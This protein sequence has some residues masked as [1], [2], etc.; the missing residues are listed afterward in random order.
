M[1]QAG[2]STSSV[3]IIVALASIA[4]STPNPW[5]ASAIRAR[6]SMSSIPA[7]EIIRLMVQVIAKSFRPFLKI[8]D[9]RCQGKDDRARISRPNSQPKPIPVPISFQFIILLQVF[10]RRLRLLTGPRDTMGQDITGSVSGR[11]GA[12]SER[13]A[14]I[15]PT[16]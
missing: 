5:F 10:T 13:P 16:P 2:L 15:R 1:R 7:S 12:G 11:R 3:F 14:R 8:C 6:V 9:Q 4:I